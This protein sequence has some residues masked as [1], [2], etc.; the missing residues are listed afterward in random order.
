MRVIAGSRRALRLDAPLGLATRPTGD[1]VREAL[2]S[3]LA[4]VAGA[5]VLDLYAGTGALGIEALSR[6]AAHA[7]FVESAREALVVLRANLERLRMP[8]ASSVIGVPA[9]RAIESVGGPFNLV[10]VDPPYV[11]LADAVEVLACAVRRGAL[12]PAVRVVL[13]HASV[14]K[15]PAIEGLTA[16]R[17][18]TYGTTSL[19]LYGLAGPAAAAP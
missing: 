18:R 16:S 19:T 10:F 4:N 14:D 8:G 11:D 2:F 6:G 3:V 1:R 5:R 15:A 13:E 17:T 7:T 12:A 9:R